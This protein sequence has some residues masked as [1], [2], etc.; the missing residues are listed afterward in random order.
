MS[1]KGKVIFADGR[2][3]GFREECTRK[4]K[5]DLDKDEN[6]LKKARFGV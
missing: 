3:D 6:H 2:K 4:D 5:S 1:A